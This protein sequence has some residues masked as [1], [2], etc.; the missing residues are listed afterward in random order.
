MINPTF[1]KKFFLVL[2]V[3]E[4]RLRFIA[5]LLITALVIGYWDTIA[6]YWDKWTRPAHVQVG[7]LAMDEEFYCPMHPQVVRDDYD[8]NGQ[9]PH[10]PICGMPL[11]LRKKGRAAPLPEGIT[12]RVQLSPDRVQLAGVETVEVGY[13]PLVRQV[14][15]VGSVAYDQSRR[16]RIT[17]RVGGYVEKLYVDKTYIPVKQD[18]PLAE[19]YSPELYSAS[20]EL[21]VAAGRGMD[22]QLVSF[23]RQR[24]KLLGVADKEIDA[25]L[26]AGKA[27]PLLLIRSPRTGQVVGKNIEA[28]SRVEQGMTLFDIADLSTVWI[29][30]DVYEKDLSILRIGQHVHATLDALPGEIFKGEVASIYSELD[31]STR[32]V[33]VRFQVDNPAGKLRPGM[34]ATVR[35]DALAEPAEQ[36]ASGGVLAVPERSVIDT[37]TRQIVYVEREPGLF[38]GRQVHL[39]LRSGEFYP[40]LTGLKPGEKVAA[41]GAFL[42]DAETRLNPSAGTYFG[43]SGGPSH[44]AA[45]NPMPAD[46]QM[47]ET[48]QSRIPA[49][50]S[51][52]EQ[53][54]ATEEAIPPEVKKNLAQLSPEDQA[55]AAHQKF[56]PVTGLMLGLM[57]VPVK[58]MLKNQPVFLCCPGCIEE[59]KSNPDRILKKVAELLKKQ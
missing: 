7:K 56:C 59:A 8:P 32:T 41:A 14:T 22:P 27:A 34:F 24:M 46:M 29:E 31:P 36:S 49:A 4:V 15:T 51:A 58:V 13:R 38:E 26:A 18:Q 16:S 53:A 48:H 1:W 23:A 3:I 39:G 43:A 28:G 37:G 2:K 12:A 33:R 21:L 20:Q 5:V 19:I 45:Q 30:A 9:V 10:C 52:K 57:G 25:I 35:I 42:I 50:T 17:S 40:V 6:N 47:D 55:L 54:K 44:T 11:S